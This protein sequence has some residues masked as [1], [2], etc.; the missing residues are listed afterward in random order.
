MDLHGTGMLLPLAPSAA[1][2]RYKVAT[3]SLIILNILQAHG[4]EKTA[5]LSHH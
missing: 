2:S 1:T 3:S 5:L 4:A